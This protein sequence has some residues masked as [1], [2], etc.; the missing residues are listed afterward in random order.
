M[1]EE[2]LEFELDEALKMIDLGEIQDGKTIMLIQHVKLKRI[3]D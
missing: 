1:I 3:L 2:V